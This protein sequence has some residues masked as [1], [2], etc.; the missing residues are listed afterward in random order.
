MNKKYIITAVIF[1]VF[2]VGVIFL[3]KSSALGN[4]VKNTEPE[5]KEFTLKAFKYGYT[6]DT[7]TV[8]KGDKVKIIIE[9]TDVPHGIRVPDFNIKGEN[10]VEFSANKTG[11]FTW[12]CAVYCGEGHM[13]MKGKLIVK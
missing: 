6:P 3:L 11:E 13:K 1:L 2:V 9:N 10:L 7:I 8:N 4:I 12:Y 5:I